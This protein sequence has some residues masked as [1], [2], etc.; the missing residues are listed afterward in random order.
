MTKDKE[1]TSGAAGLANEEE[2]QEA[3]QTGPL[4]PGF[5]DDFNNWLDSVGLRDSGYTYHN[6]LHRFKEDKTLSHLKTYHNI[7]PELD[8]IG[9]EFGGG[10]Y[11]LNCFVFVDGKRRKEKVGSGTVF[12]LDDSWN[13]RKREA[14]ELKKASAAKP[15]QVSGAMNDT[16]QI[17]ALV[18]S[19]LTTAQATAKQPANDSTSLVRLV[20]TMIEEQMKSN[21]KLIAQTR[22]QLM[23]EAVEGEF[24]PIP[25]ATQADPPNPLIETIAGLI[26][27]YA[28]TLLGGGPAAEAVIKAAKGFL[29]GPAAQPIIND[30]EAMRRI[31]NAVNLKYGPDKTRQL[32]GMIG[33]KL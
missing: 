33:F 28:P 17:V 22:R 24:S 5:S 15:L 31:V 11:K 23:A 25:A 13:E 32:F 29:A 27:Q 12:S 16:A 6:Y 3:K 10:K 4:A 9:I 18:Q 26:E 1:E 20:N 7:F 14:D 30:P 19:L 8:D 21:F 2:T